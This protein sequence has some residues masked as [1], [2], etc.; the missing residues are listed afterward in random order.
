MEFAKLCL[1]AFLNIK[2]ATYPQTHRHLICSLYMFCLRS[3]ESLIKFLTNLCLF[4]P[5]VTYKLNS[6]ENKKVLYYDILC[7]CLEY[8]IIYNTNIYTG[9]VLRGNRHKSH[10]YSSHE[11]NEKIPE[12]PL[13]ILRTTVALL[14]KLP[15]ML[16]ITLNFA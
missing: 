14:E 12:T 7:M 6:A 1:S 13:N 4:F 16:Y 3:K 9:S 5:L 8:F 10:V 11:N 15:L 2:F